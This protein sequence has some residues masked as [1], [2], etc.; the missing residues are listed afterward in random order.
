MN[1]PKLT[2]DILKGKNIFI[3]LEGEY[4]LGETQ[5]CLRGDWNLYIKD[6]RIYLEDDK[7]I[8]IVDNKSLLSPR[9]WADSF[10][11][12]KEK[13]VVVEE[14]YYYRGA[15]RVDLMDDELLIQNRVDVDFFISSIL[16]RQFADND[17]LEF[18]KAMAIVYRSYLLKYIH[19]LNT[20]SFIQEKN[21]QEFLLYV[22]NFVSPNPERLEFKYKGISIEGNEILRKAVN[23]TKGEVLFHNSQIVSLPH[24]FCCGG[25]PENSYYRGEKQFNEY[26]N[27]LKDKDGHDT[28]SS[29][30]KEDVQSWIYHPEDFY[31]NTRNPEIIDKIFSGEIGDKNNYFRWRV[32]VKLSLLVEILKTKFDFNV[33]DINEF[34]V[35]DRSV[36]GSVNT[37]EVNNGQNKIVISEKELMLLA[38][39]L[40]LPSLTFISRIISDE[41]KIAFAG[42]GKGHRAGL[43][44]VGAMAMAKEG[45]TVNDI[46]NHYYANIYISKQY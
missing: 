18:L 37:V 6:N 8:I 12:V 10:F 4:Y 17:H 2:I 20:T 35:K 25:I 45:K 36:R 42:A 39:Y 40:K 11:V 7:E 15:V 9:N 23:E 41:G 30:N 27:N 44:M 16:D 43:C 46:I 26:L 29:L 5:R 31:C 19:E 3:S 14:K 1:N 32:E 22:N 21:P 13:G 28:I 34:I 38:A 33:C 24:T